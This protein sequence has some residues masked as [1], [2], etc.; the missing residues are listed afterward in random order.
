MQL[1]QIQPALGA[2]LKVVRDL[3]LLEQWYQIGA[4]VPQTVEQLAKLAGCDGFLLGW[5]I[6]R[7]A[8]PWGTRY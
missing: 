5:S 6:A 2:S 4:D 8:M 1:I 7:E 3:R